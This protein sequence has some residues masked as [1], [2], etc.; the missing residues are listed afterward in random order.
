MRG[1]TIICNIVSLSSY[2]QSRI[3]LFGAPVR[4]AYVFL[5]RQGNTL[6]VHREERLTAGT[7]S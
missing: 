4:K 5:T 7:I 3:I 2:L 1:T 6:P